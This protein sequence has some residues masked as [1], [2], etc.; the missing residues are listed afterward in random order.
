MSLTIEE[1]KNFFKEEKFAYSE[2]VDYFFLV[3]ESKPTLDKLKKDYGNYLSEEEIIE[4]FK[5]QSDYWAKIQKFIEKFG[6]FECVENDER[7]GD[8]YDYMQYVFHI[9]NH[10]MYFAVRGSYSS[11]DGCDYSYATLFEV[12]PQIYT[13]YVAI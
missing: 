6:Q 2:F 13:T 10:D 1:I 9:V 7:C 5:K 4:K 11:W 3:K 12:K 8:D